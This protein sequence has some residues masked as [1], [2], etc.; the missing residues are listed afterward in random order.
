MKN[1]ENYRFVFEDN[2]KEEDKY[3]IHIEISN[4][5]LQNLFNGDINRFKK[6]CAEII[7]ESAGIE[8]IE[9]IERKIKFHERY[10]RLL[11]K[12]RIRLLKKDT[13]PIYPT[14]SPCPYPHTTTTS[15]AEDSFTYSDE[16]KV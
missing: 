10:I 3:T 9:K 15:W 12:K 6:H 11:R 2:D 13:K 7:L 14:W 1:M 5:Q 16:F 8:K 4:W